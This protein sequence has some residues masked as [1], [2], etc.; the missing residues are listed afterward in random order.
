V[1]AGADGTDVTLE[2]AAG[3]RV[4]VDRLAHRH[5]IT[6]SAVGRKIWLFD[7]EGPGPGRD[8]KGNRHL[9]VFYGK[10]G[11]LRPRWPGLSPHQVG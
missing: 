8:F 9:F 6:A 2:D 1:N 11:E 3:R 4:R 5:G 7:L 10:L